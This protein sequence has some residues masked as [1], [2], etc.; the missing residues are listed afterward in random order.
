MFARVSRIQG[1]PAQAEKAAAGPTPSEIQ[2]LAGYR[3][4]YVLL[5]RMNGKVMIMTL[6]ETEE[7][8][9]ASAEVANRIRRQ[10]AEEAGAT[11]PPVVEMYEVVSQP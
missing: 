1:S 2:R 7:A 9:Q 3:G 8:M 6:W 11:A 10:T 4:A 5:D